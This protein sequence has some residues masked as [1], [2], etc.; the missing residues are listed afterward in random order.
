MSVRVVQSIAS[1]VQQAGVAEERYLGAADLERK[2]LTNGDLRLPREEIFRLTEL[3]LDITGDPAFGL[4]WGERLSDPSLALM[5]HLLANAAN[6]RTALGLLLEF[7]ALLNDDMELE[8][9][10]RNGAVTL[11]CDGPIGNSLRYQRIAAEMVTLGI[12]RLIRQF[13]PDASIERVS[14]SYRAPD[15]RNEYTRVFQSHERF[16]EQFTGLVFDSVALDARAPFRDEALWNNLR[17]L[18][19]QRITKLKRCTPYSRQVS[20]LLLQEPAPHRI[21]AVEVARA[22]GMSERSLHR[23][24]AEVG[25]PFRVIARE[26]A[27]TVA[28][29]LLEQEQLTVKE[30]AYEMGYSDASSFHRAC[31]RWTGKPPG[32]FRHRPPN[33]RARR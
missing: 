19:Q 23:R 29:R 32:A 31:K 27:A 21:S 33:E 4:H 12:F 7:G 26:A 25:R 30:A 9:T 10:E 11:R 6:L 28:H 20:E 16:N 3:A 18:A 24:L 1:A 17:D 22:L 5:S 15:Y 2:D 8:L 14:F 13:S